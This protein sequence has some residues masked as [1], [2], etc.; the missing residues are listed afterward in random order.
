MVIVAIGV[1][2][3]LVGFIINVPLMITVGGFV[4]IFID[5]LGMLR[6]ILKP[7][8]PI[9][10]YIIGFAIFQSWIGILYASILFNSIELVVLLVSTVFF[11]VQTKTSPKESS[12]TGDVD[13]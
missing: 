6:G 11:L 3:A 12:S 2:L 4:C 10:S 7:L 1:L 13:N 5:I 8:M 9:L